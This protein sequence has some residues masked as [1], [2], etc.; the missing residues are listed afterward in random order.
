MSGKVAPAGV[1]RTGTTGGPRN[2]AGK[3]SRGLSRSFTRTRTIKQVTDKEWAKAQKS[4]V[5][6]LPDEV[7]KQIK[8]VFKSFAG[9]EPTVIVD[10][11]TLSEM[12][13]GLGWDLLPGELDVLIHKYRF[14]EH[15]TEI[16]LSIFQGMLYN[17][18]CG[19]ISDDEL[20][21]AFL[22]FDQDDNGKIDKSELSDAFKCLDKKQ[23]SADEC[24]EMLE[25]ADIDKDGCIDIDEFINLLT[26]SK[27]PLLKHLGEPPEGA[28]S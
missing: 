28:E 18:I 10:K 26:N 19:E 16:S 7:L 21:A 6:E 25:E 20:R 3:I 22:A 15:E 1:L 23:F 12:L 17:K 9:E 27:R 24:H 14:D 2:G 4:A 11:M 5:L 13:S 8:T